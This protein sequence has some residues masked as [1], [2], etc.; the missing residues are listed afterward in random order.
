MRKLELTFV[1]SVGFVLAAGLAM[2]DCSRA[3]TPDPVPRSAAASP[4][5]L[6][7][8]PAAS[9]TPAA[10]PAQAAPTAKAYDETTTAIDTLVGEKFAVYLPANITTPYKWVV[11]PSDTSPIVVLADHHYQDKPPEGCPACVGYPGTDILNF[12]AKAAGT[13]TLKL[14]CAP[15]RSK[16]E[17][18]ARELTI[19]VTVQKRQ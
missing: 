6:V 11:A 15:L 2:T 10:T 14:K 17:P 7:T 18:A 16:T 5:P 8:A 3:G 13:T 1:V 9:E 19:Q 4:S 12:E